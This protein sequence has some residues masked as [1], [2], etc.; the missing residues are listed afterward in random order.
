MNG[1]DQCL[2]VVH[3]EGINFRPVGFPKTSAPKAQGWGFMKRPVSI[4]EIEGTLQ[5]ADGVVI[6]F[7]APAMAVRDGYETRVTDLRKNKM[8]DVW[9]PNAIEN[10]S[11]R[12]HCCDGHVVPPKPCRAVREV[13]VEDVIAQSRIR[14]ATQ[15]PQ[16]TVVGKLFFEGECAQVDLAL[17]YFEALSSSTQ[18]S[19]RGRALD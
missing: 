4:S 16:E 11:I 7:F 19:L 9:A 15:A 10:F 5:N 6:G 12:P 17:D 8:A 2:G 3:A 13:C 18:V 14:H 1:S